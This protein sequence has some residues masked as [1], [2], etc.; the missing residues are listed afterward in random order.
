MAE[1]ATDLVDLLSLSLDTVGFTRTVTDVLI[2]DKLREKKLQRAL[3]RERKNAAL[4]NTSKD[5]F[6][7]EFGSSERIE[8][9]IIRETPATDESAVDLTKVDLDAI[10][11]CY[12]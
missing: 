7:R 9:S 3:Q 10:E 5:E 2:L 11:T 4:Q 12:K 6:I 8:H 1:A